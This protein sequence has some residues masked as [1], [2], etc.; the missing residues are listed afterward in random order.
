[1]N[2][3]PPAAPE[4]RRGTGCKDARAPAFLRRRIGA[5]IHP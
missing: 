3:T 5:E 4:I 1:M 2:A